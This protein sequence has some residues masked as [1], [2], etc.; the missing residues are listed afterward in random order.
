M[1]SWVVAEF[2]SADS[3]ERAYES[4]R[5]AGYTRLDTWTPYPSR[6]LVKML[7]ESI[8]PYLMLV[9]GLLGGGFGYLLQW[10]VNERAFRINVGG[11]P[12]NSAP[13][14]IPIAF[15]SAILAA[16]LA[17][18]FG[19]LWACRLPRLYHPLF[20]VDG[21][22]SASVDRFWLGVDSSDPLF[23]ERVTG[24]LTDMGA[25]QCARK[26]MAT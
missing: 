3:L 2:E 26:E 24:E 16:S 14:F 22:E 18:F 12:L 23:D 8:V 15:E 7:P 25:I 4:L 10:W 6:A 9:G 13:A 19:L 21:F 11:R 17:G 1:P 20:E 5:R